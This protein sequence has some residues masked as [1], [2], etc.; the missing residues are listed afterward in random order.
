MSWMEPVIYLEN[1]TMFR[2]VQVGVDFWVKTYV[3]N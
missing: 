2:K 1:L 3:P